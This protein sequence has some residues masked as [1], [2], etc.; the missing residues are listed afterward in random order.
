[1]QESNSVFSKLEYNIE[2]SAQRLT[3]GDLIAQAEKDP[4]AGYCKREARRIQAARE[5]V[6]VQKQLLNDCRSARAPVDVSE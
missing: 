3:F 4:T 2:S 1:M 5:P 6:D